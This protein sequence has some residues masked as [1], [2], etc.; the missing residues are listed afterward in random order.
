M[1]SAWLNSSDDD[2]GAKLSREL[3]GELLGPRVRKT[4]HNPEGIK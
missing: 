4:S 2:G 1:K 3:L